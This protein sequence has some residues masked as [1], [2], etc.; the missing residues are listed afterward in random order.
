MK[1]IKVTIASNLKPSKISI[2]DIIV[3]LEKEVKE[4]GEHAHRCEED[5][6][7]GNNPSVREMYNKA[8]ARRDF[9]SYLLMSIK[10]NS[11]HYLK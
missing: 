4:N 10:T 3:Y 8:E 7:R 1:K 5:L 6:K 9:A 2:K 11:P